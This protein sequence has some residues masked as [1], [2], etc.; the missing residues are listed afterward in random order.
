MSDAKRVKVDLRPA[1]IE[2][3]YN[4]GQYLIDLV[5]DKTTTKYIASGTYGWVYR[6]VISAQNGETQA[7][8]L[9]CMKTKSILKYKKEKIPFLN[10]MIETTD[11]ELWP[12]VEIHGTQYKPHYFEGLMQSDTPG[13]MEDVVACVMGIVDTYSW[14]SSVFK[15]EVAELERTIQVRLKEVKA[16]QL[17]LD[18]DSSSAQET[19]LRTA[20]HNLEMEKEKLEL[21][22]ANNLSRES[23]IFKQLAQR[24]LSNQV[25]I[26]DFKDQNLGWNGTECC[27]IDI[28]GLL[29]RNNIFMG[30]DTVYLELNFRTTFIRK[31]IV[32]YLEPRQKWN[33][34]T[35]KYDSY[36]SEVKRRAR[37]LTRA[38]NGN[39]END[40]L[41]DASALQLELITLYLMMQKVA[42]DQFRVSDIVEYDVGKAFSKMMSGVNKWWLDISLPKYKSTGS[43]F[44]EIPKMS[45]FGAIE[46]SEY[47]Q[48]LIWFHDTFQEKA[49]LV[50][51]TVSTLEKASL[52]A[53]FGNGTETLFLDRTLS[54]C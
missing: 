54:I 51:A 47:Y 12:C 28:D 46:V 17:E 48:N 4:N 25:Y 5:S 38:S 21:T 24:C 3:G 27:L 30:R 7:V 35:K 13:M 18:K 45:K 29:S 23:N 6:V 11:N 41:N 53:A 9:K 22:N 15:K 8:A 34:L 26:L 33:P 1:T 39:P 40:N 49:S 44:P 52:L 32:P 20:E 50:K 16:K 19:A 43:L 2:E 36:K 10:K 42:Y 14:A 37:V 31:Q